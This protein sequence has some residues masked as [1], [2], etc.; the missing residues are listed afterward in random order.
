[1]ST[2][3]VVVNHTSGMSFDANVNEHH[4][5]VDAKDEVGG[6]NL[7]PTPKPLVLIALAGC[8]GMD[9]V[10]LL[11]KMRQD[12]SDL[13]ISVTGELTEDHPKYY[14]KI[15][16]D[17]TLLGSGLD[18]SKVKKAVDLSQDKYCGVSHMLKAAAE[19]TYSISINGLKL[20]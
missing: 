1:M 6:Q 13:K 18:A 20:D 9:V 10:S 19:L 2:E 11:N 14:H 3:V 4:I 8:T 7:G 12:Y 16:V 5:I 17:Y 15:H